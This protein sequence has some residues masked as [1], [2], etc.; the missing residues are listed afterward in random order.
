VST[1]GEKDLLGWI[2]WWNKDQTDRTM[3][4]RLAYHVGE[5]FRTVDKAVRYLWDE[6]A[7]QLDWLLGSDLRSFSNNVKTSPRP[8]RRGLLRCQRKKI[9]LLRTQELLVALRSPL[10][11]E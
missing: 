6:T 7:M 5:C 8:G 10:I 4:P 1:C 2:E 9:D 11:V 3:S